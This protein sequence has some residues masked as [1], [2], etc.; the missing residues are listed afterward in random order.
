MAEINTTK[1]G[2]PS[3]QKASPDGNGETTPKVEAKTYTQEDIDKAVHAAVSQ[4]GRDAKSLQVR[5]QNLTKREEAFNQ[6]EAEKEAAELAEAQKDPNKLAVY[7]AKKAE[8]ERTKS[9][10]EREADLARR[11][12]EHEAEITA[13]KEAQKEITIWQVA[14]AKNVDPMRLK[15]LSEKYNVE[16]KEKLEELAADIASGKPPDEPPDKTKT[17]D[18]LVTSGN[19]QT[20]EGK[21]SRQIF[22]DVF[23]DKSNK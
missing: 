14:S 7:N 19:R 6:K 20:S 12:A 16:G 18:P 10:D 5:E 17:P 4:A 8:R 2:A 21:T 3:T 9:L 15:D 23:R 22:A 11:E 13:A 1:Q